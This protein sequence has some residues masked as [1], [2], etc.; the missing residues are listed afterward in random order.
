MS[1][2]AE[3]TE[4]DG[5]GLADLVRSKEV[6]A[7]EVL[8]AA[9]GRIEALNPALNAV[10]TRVYD[11]ARAAAPDGTAC[12]VYGRAVPLEGPGRCSGRRADDRRLALLRPC[13]R[14]GRC[15]DGGALQARGPSHPRPHQHAR[16]RPQRLDR[17]GAVRPDP[18]PL[19]P[20]PLERRLERRL[21]GRGRRPH[22]AARA[23]QRRR[24]LDPHPR[25]LLRPVRPQDHA[26]AP[27][28]RAL[29]RRGAGRLLGRARGLAQRARQRRRPR[30]QRGP[31]RR[32]PL[33]SAAALAPVPRGGRRRPCPAS[34]RAC[35]RSVRRRPGR[36]GLRRRRAKPPRHFARSSATTSSAPHPP[37]MSP[38][39][40]R[41]TTWSSRSTPRPTSGCAP[42]R[43]ASPSIPPPSS[44]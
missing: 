4:Y 41:P 28:L 38:G 5:L 7:E 19:G 21:G 44:A 27:V 12:A 16:V 18:Q 8:E 43:S 30:C 20:R 14:T 25:L 32:R 1:G 42:A 11:E 29:C 6:S 22:G 13:A 26:R 9:I 40:T 37:T 23:C 36:P 2:F 31:G 15:R 39:W 33:F 17:A 10:V 3:Y 34:H 24:R 35:D